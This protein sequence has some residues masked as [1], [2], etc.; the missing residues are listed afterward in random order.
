VKEVAPFSPRG[1]RARA[2][3]AASIRRA[4]VAGTGRQDEGCKT[5]SQTGNAPSRSQ[6][7]TISTHASSAT[8]AVSH[9]RAPEDPPRHKPSREAALRAEKKKRKET[10]NPLLLHA[11]VAR[12]VGF[13][14][15]LPTHTHH[16]NTMRQAFP[17]L[18]PPITALGAPQRRAQVG[19][20]TRGARCWLL[21]AGCWLKHMACRPAAQAVQSS[22][23][24][25]R[26]PR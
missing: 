6:L 20:H 12:A 2:R 18:L 10:E 22:A 1:P 17:L 3:I 19:S 11:G 24:F 26:R 13:H 25:G 16:D 21:A 9:P 23:G 15:R 5:R 7:T 8:Y 14:V 4:L